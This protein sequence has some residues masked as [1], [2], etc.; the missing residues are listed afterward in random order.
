[1]YFWNNKNGIFLSA[2]NAEGYRKKMFKS[3]SDCPPV[4]LRE[5]TFASIEAVIFN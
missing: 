3:G 4:Q 5:K 1:M 2:K